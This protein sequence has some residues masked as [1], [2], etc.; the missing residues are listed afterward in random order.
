ML[1]YVCKGDSIVI[2]ASIGGLSIKTNGVAQQDGNL[3]DTIMVRNSHSKKV[4][5]AKVTKSSEVSVVI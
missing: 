1:C 5:D 2:N 3:G 4:I